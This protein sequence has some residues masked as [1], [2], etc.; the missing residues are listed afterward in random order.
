MMMM[1]MDA[2]GW[3]RE[4]FKGKAVDERNFFLTSLGEG[5]IGTLRGQPLLVGVD[6]PRRRLS[7]IQLHWTGQHR[8][9]PT[10]H[11]QSLCHP[12]L[13]YVE[14]RPP[15]HQPTSTPLTI[16]TVKPNDKAVSQRSNAR[17][18][19]GTST[20]HIASSHP[21]GSTP[22]HAAANPW[23][24]VRN[25][26]KFFCSCR[27]SVAVFAFGMEDVNGGG[28]EWFFRLAVKGEREERAGGGKLAFGR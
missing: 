19:T 15:H 16:W 9:Q 3:I 10:K 26:Q 2:D 5:R 11:L 17:P 20:C 13:S 12:T 8:I 22:A 25:G 27:F 6:S 28:G 4:E 18:R 23:R 14:Y 21:T 1:M 7:S 24:R